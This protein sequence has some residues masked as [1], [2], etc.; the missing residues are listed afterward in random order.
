[1]TQKSART[2]ARIMEAARGEFARRGFQA[3]TVRAIATEAQIDPS[4][5]I[6]YFDS[7]AG[8]FDAVCQ[9]SLL[10]PPLQ[11][12]PRHEIGTTLVRHFLAR[13]DGDGTDDSLLLLLRSGVVDPEAAARLHKL[14][15]TQ[16]LP[17]LSEVVDNPA[18]ASSR[19][20]LV[21]SQMLGVALTRS[22]LQIPPMVAMTPDQIVARIGPTVQ[23]YLTG[24][25]P[26]R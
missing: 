19:V 12:V 18:E 26:A 13:W 15:A 1:M 14:F 7:K 9:I 16:L 24:P 25:L 22:I 11:D 6:R 17:A 8:L 21:A 5:I 23:A 10:I 3:A 20:G 2:K 4:M